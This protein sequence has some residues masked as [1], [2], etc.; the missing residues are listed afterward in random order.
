MVMVS[1][2]LLLK[3]AVSQDLL[4]AFSQMDVKPQ[5]VRAGQTRTRIFASLCIRRKGF[6]P[7]RRYFA[8]SMGE[9]ATLAENDANT[10]DATYC[11]R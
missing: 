7:T 11:R 8:N 6:L 3:R 2:F 1:M 5:I 9:D 4:K 10:K